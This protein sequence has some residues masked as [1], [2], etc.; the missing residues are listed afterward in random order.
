MA[1]W[2]EVFRDEAV[3]VYADPA[4]IS[5]TANRAQLWVLYDYQSVQSSNSSRPY[6][7]SRR[8]SEYDCMEGQS[9]ILSLTGHSANMAE[10]DTVFTLSNPEEWETVP[11]SSIAELMWKIACGK[12]A[13]KQIQ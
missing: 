1:E 6:R 5:K 11:P 9:R 3:T 13:V 4:T 10:A 12:T 8:Q 2:V 7:S